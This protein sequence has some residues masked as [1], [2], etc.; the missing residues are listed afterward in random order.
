M[1]NLKRLE[2]YVRREMG[3]VRCGPVPLA[4]SSDLSDEGEPLRWTLSWVRSCCRSSDTSARTTE[5]AAK[6]HSRVPFR[7]R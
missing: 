6:A 5:G 4:P 1:S 7:V 3:Q 2:P